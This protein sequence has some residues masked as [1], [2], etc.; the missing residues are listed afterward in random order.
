MTAQPKIT[1][2]TT[3]AALRAHHPCATGWATLLKSL[4]AD[5]PHDKPINLLHI[6]KSN[7]V[8]DM[9]WALRATDSTPQLRVAMCADMAKRVLSLFEARHPDNPRPRECITACRHFVRGAITQQQLFTAAYAAYAAYA[10]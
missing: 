6:L 8:Q 5:Y 7:G 4:P 9:M 1:L 2:T 3:V 10:A